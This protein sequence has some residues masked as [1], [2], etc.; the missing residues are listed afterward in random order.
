MEAPN[1]DITGSK[2]APTFHECA[3][4]HDNCSE[5]V[6]HS[7]S[8]IA[9]LMCLSINSPGASTFYDWTRL[10]DELKVEVLTHHLDQDDSIDKDKHEVIFDS[11]LEPLISTGNRAL[12]TIASETY[13]TRNLF[14]VTFCNSREAWFL[15]YPPTPY[16]HLIRHLEVENPRSSLIRSIDKL[17]HSFTAWRY[18]LSSTRPENVAWQANFPNLQTLRI[19][20]SRIHEGPWMVR[21]FRECPGCQLYW[22]SIQKFTEVLAQTSIELKA[23][24]VTA[25]DSTKSDCGCLNETLRTIERM[26]TKPKA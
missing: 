17:G 25:F 24:K 21:T 7:V 15:Y 10:P 20:M 3:K 26:A 11:R 2:A 22:L 9:R 18:L 23:K 4:D 14:K 13:Y 19:S 8:K 6:E 5:Q 16:G 1:V 12:V